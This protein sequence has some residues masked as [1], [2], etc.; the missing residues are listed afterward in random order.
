MFGAGGR[1]DVSLE[2]ALYA[3]CALPL[4]FP[5]ASIGGRLY[6]DGGLR[7]VLPLDQAA[8]FEPDVLFAVDVGPSWREEPPDRP[9]RVPPMVRRSGQVQRVMMAAQTEGE[10]ARWRAR[11]P[12]SRPELILVE[13]AVRAETTFRLDLVSPYAEEGYRAATAVLSARRVP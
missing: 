13:P 5:P 9:L 8:L 10:V 11:P 6:V 4:Y 3:T 2:D 7:S 12:G 1:T